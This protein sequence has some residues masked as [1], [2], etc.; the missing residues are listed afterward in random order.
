MKRIL[1]FLIVVAL[2][3]CSCKKT[4]VE[5]TENGRSTSIHTNT[6]AVNTTDG[7][8]SETAAETT[9]YTDDT[10]DA[11]EETIATSTRRDTTST[12]VVMTKPDSGA[13][14]DIQPIFGNNRIKRVKCL[15][16]NIRAL[17]KV[18]FELDIT[19]ITGNVFDPENVSLEMEL[20][21]SA[22]TRL[23]SIGFYY[24]PYS[25]EIDGAIGSKSGDGTWRFRFTPTVPGT[26]D[27]KIVLKEKGAVADTITGYV[28]VQAPDDTRGFVRV[29]PKLK[30]NFVFDNKT[31]YIPIGE[32]VAWSIPVSKTQY[33]ATY[34][35]GIF[36][37]M[38]TNGANYARVWLAN[39]DLTLLSSKAPPSVLNMAK[40]AQLDQIVE[41]LREKD[42]YISLV[43]YHHGQ[44]SET[45]DPNWNGCAYNAATGFGY[46]NSPK[47]F[48]TNNQAKKDARIFIRYLVARYGYSTN[49]MSW[50]LFNE[51]DISDGNMADI[52]EWHKEMVDYLRSIDTYNHLISTSCSNRNNSLA[53]STLFDFATIHWY[54][55]N[56]VK[57]L[58]DLQK[59]IWY[60]KKMPVLFGEVGDII[61]GSD[62]P[63]VD[64]DFI[65]IHQQNWAGV[66]GGGAGTGMNWF[67]EQMDNLNGYDVYRGISNFAKRI[68]WNDENRSFVSTSIV[69]GNNSQVEVTGYYNRRNYAYLWLYDKNYTHLKKNKTTFNNYTFT[70]P[71][72]E[73]GVYMIEWYDT[74]AGRTIQID[75]AEAKGGN[76][77]VKAPTWDRDIAVSIFK[78]K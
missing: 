53:T 61:K 75:K 40:A 32:N 35:K 42:I 22:G 67:Y 64:K 36:E 10:T 70:I 7:V 29:E 58:I 57:N 1:P 31:P 27:F 77:V 66:M 37:K 15:T 56:G 21:S 69:G 62:I 63:S 55:Y 9:E 24:E 48:F 13:I 73:N 6:T 18:E 54:N 50:E 5:S 39:W 30:Q 26:W 41:Y 19:G 23:N 33:A 43:I 20:V 71:M 38:S 8:T 4:P 3:S 17:R 52:I 11:P 25:W 76:L 44:F 16:G 47:E 2:L 59:S 78:S 72:E 68:P 65:N 51:A 28:N 12:K 46:L 49:I 45:V 14:N 74:R 34:F 60:S